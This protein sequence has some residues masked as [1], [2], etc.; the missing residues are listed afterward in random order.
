MEKYSN[1]RAANTTAK[2]KDPV[3]GVKSVAGLVPVFRD[4]ATPTRT[5]RV[6]DVGTELKLGT[7]LLQSISYLLQSILVG[8]RTE[9]NRNYDVH[10]PSATARMECD[11]SVAPPLTMPGQLLCRGRG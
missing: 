11:G 2:C 6:V 10:T 1:Q 9:L 8:G 5:R 7:K 4:W 3:S